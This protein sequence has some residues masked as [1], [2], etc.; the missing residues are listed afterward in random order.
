[1]MLFHELMMSFLVYLLLIVFFSWFKSVTKSC[2]MFLK[3]GNTW[4]F[5]FFLFFADNKD[6][7]RLR[8]NDLVIRKLKEDPDIIDIPRR[9]EAVPT[10]KLET[11]SS[12]LT[13]SVEVYV[14]MA[15][16]TSMYY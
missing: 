12:A 15:D 1:M 13:K 16:D 14:L 10:M 11:K 2:L 9:G 5:N 8:I 4:A 3:L 7:E 6:V